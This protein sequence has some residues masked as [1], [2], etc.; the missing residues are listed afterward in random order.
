M[1]FKVI[2][3]GV[4]ISLFILMQGIKYKIAITKSEIITTQLQISAL[5][6]LITIATVIVEYKFVDMVPNGIKYLFYYSVPIW[7]AYY[8]FK[9]K[10][11]AEEIT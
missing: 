1:W 3:D 4:L 7:V 2:I 10:F 8:Y 6:T 11:S 9:R 5:G